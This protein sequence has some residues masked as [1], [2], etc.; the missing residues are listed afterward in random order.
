MP[1]PEHPSLSPDRIDTEGLLWSLPRLPEPSLPERYPPVSGT[2]ERPTR[3]ERLGELEPV[4]L[5]QGTELQGRLLEREAPPP[6]E[7]GPGPP[8]P[9]PRQD[10]LPALRP[11]VPLCPDVA[12]PIMDGQK[13]FLTG[14]GE[15]T[16]T[17]SAIDTA[18]ELVEGTESDL[19]QLVEAALPL[20]A[21]A[22]H[23][24]FRRFL[25]KTP[26]AQLP[27][28]IGEVQRSVVLDHARLQ[29]ELRTLQLQ[30]C[31]LERRQLL[32]C[33]EPNQRG[34]RVLRGDSPL[35]RQTARSSS[36]FSRGRSPSPSKAQGVGPP[37]ASSTGSPNR[38]LIDR[39]SPPPSSGHQAS[40][41]SPMRAVPL[42]DR[43]LGVG[44]QQS[45][46]ATYLGAMLPRQSVPANTCLQ[47][48]ATSPIRASHFYWQSPCSAAA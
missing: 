31:L 9:Q 33:K 5:G 39:P 38:R 47:R 46:S 23:G 1:S 36:S 3:T 21:L 34:Q 40:G 29:S 27:I 28:T 22:S 8:G 26:E 15:E 2:Q 30:R 18:S 44:G 35:P 17:A 41:A 10:Q 19:L 45:K 6:K 24:A 11:D 12:R 48:T 32:Q 14:P 16:L 4:M 42:S 25:A 20:G 37:R 7:V 43:R 13:H